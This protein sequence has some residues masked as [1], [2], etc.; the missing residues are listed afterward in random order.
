MRGSGEQPTP[1]AMASMISRRKTF[2]QNPCFAPAI[3]ALRPPFF[4]FCN[5][6]R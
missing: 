2:E 5:A 1:G 4:L 6:E 3:H